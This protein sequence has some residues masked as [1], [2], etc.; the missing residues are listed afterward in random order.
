MAFW[1]ETD[2]QLAAAVPTD[3]H[4]FV[5]RLAE[6]GLLVRCYTQ[7]I[8]GL[9]LKAGIP[10]DRLVQA[11]GS[12]AS[13]RCIGPEQHACEVEHVRAAAMAGDVPRCP[14]CGVPAKPD[15]VFFGEPLPRRFASL[16]EHDLSNCELLIVMGTSLSVQPFGALPNRVP[17]TCVR[18]VINREP[19]RD[20]ASLF[21]FDAPQNYR[22]VFFRGTCDDG[23]AALGRK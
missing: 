2:A 1:R 19:L 7:N 11:H 21:D 6:D 17:D 22:D 8:D 12:F 23:V 14:A 9:E 15:I 5:R 13:A 16:I 4:R 10:P 18:V 3:A 20:T